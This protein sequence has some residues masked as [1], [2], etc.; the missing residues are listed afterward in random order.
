MFDTSSPYISALISKPEQKIR[1]SYRAYSIRTPNPGY[2]RRQCALKLPVPPCFGPDHS[3]FSSELRHP[4][5]EPEPRSIRILARPARRIQAGCGKAEPAKQGKR[6]P[7]RDNLLRVLSN[8]HFDERQAQRYVS[9]RY[10]YGLQFAVDELSVQHKFYHSLTPAQQR[11]WLQ[12][13][14]Y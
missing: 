14:L 6:T 9:E 2:P 1:R 13:C 5:T 11:I 10:G 12:K 4:P 8:P 3:G 7:L